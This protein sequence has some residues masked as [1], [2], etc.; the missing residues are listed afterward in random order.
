MI[1]SHELQLPVGTVKETTAKFPSNQI[2]LKI[3]TQRNTSILEIVNTI[4]V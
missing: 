3:L 1:F 2:D 4:P